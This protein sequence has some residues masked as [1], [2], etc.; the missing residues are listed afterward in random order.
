MVVVSV[1][2][3]TEVLT[4]V[5]VEGVGASVVVGVVV[6]GA[7]VVTVTVEGGAAVDVD[8]CAVLCSVGTGCGAVD[9][10]VADGV[11]GLLPVAVTLLDVPAGVGELPELVN[12][13]TA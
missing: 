13:T 6:V 7:V 10:A 12:V 1:T 5:V 8:G 3:V 4:L 9:V 11:L 2:V